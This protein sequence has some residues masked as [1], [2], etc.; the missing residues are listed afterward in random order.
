MN[1]QGQKHEAQT[2]T[3][4]GGGLLDEDLETI[5]AM[6]EHRADQYVFSTRL[7]A[8]FEWEPFE[9]ERLFTSVAPMPEITE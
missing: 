4:S 2:E 7:N 9:V 8:F 6:Q 5:M 1:T 3:E